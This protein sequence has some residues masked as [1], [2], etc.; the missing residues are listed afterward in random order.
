MGN[1][2]RGRD[3]MEVVVGGKKCDSAVV[4]VRE[5]MGMRAGEE[6]RILRN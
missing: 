4:V 5:V 3:L 6:G 2:R 1:G